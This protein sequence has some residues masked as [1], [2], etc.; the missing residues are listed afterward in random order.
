[1]KKLPLSLALILWMIAI[2]GCNNVERKAKENLHNYIE[3]VCPSSKIS[4]ISVILSE[5]KDTVINDLSYFNKICVLQTT[6]K[7]KEGNKRYEYIF[8]S[9]GNNNG[10]L[11]EKDTLYP[12]HIGQSGFYGS[13]ANE[14][15][16]MS[17]E[18]RLNTSLYHIAFK[19]V[20]LSSHIVTAKLSL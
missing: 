3:S 4:D 5:C 12:I 7:S 9:S 10:L 17:N 1:M 15:G 18:D 20:E 14:F 2:A 8:Q 16:K 13:I 11:I 19:R 6:I